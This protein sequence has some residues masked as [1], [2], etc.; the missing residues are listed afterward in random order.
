MTEM[1]AE[2]VEQRGERRCILVFDGTTFVKKGSASCGVKRQWCGR[3]GKVENCQAGVFMAYATSR[4]YAPLDRRLYLPEDLAG[5]ARHRRK[6][7]VPPQVDYLPK[8]G[9]ALQMLERHGSQVPHAWITADDE[10]G[11]ASEFR[12]ALRERGETYVLEIPSNTLIRDLDQRLPPR[13][14]RR[15][16]PRKA[17]WQSVA[18]WTRRHWLRRGKRLTLRQ[19][20]KGPVRVRLLS[21]RVQ[22][23]RDGRPGPTERLIAFQTLEQ[24][25]RT[26]YA[27][28]NAPHGTSEEEYLRVLAARHSIEELFE[29]AK[30]EAGLAHYEVRSWTGWHHHVTLSLLALWFLIQERARLGKKNPGLDGPA[31][32]LPLL[33][34]AS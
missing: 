33:S 23:R 21:L 19:G 28:S 7:H 9:L 14:S 17:S 10:F 5:D 18:A 31:N 34:A 6:T 13:H 20:S 8:W 16:R 32:G 12:A 15:G 11:R 4:G 26:V 30:G 27:L 1:R 24:E 3:L 22:T 29:A 2:V 25:P